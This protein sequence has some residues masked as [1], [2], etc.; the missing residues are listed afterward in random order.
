MENKLTTPTTLFS[1]K[2]RQ[3]LL[4]LFFTNPES[5]YYTRQLQSI[6]EV[7]V[8]SLHRELKKLEK[9]GVL[10]SAKEGNLLFYT[11]DKNYPLYNELKSLVFKT[12]GAEGAIKEALF[13][14]Q[15]VKFAFLYG[16]FASKK[17][18]ATS[19]IDLFL[20]GE[21]DESSLLK[22]IPLLEKSLARE[23]NYLIA[24]ESEFKKDVRNKEPFIINLLKEPKVFLIGDEDG[25]RKLA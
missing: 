13:H 10:K 9:M 22:E 20:I 6:L 5:R 19:D 17:E 3:E 25:F 2:I 24:T 14:I 11:V 12:I 7:S 15:G 4:R 8:G 23:I 1:S 18:R 21:I 16:S